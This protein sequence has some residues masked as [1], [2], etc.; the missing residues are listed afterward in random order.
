LVLIL[1]MRRV[2]RHQMAVRFLLFIMTLNPCLCIFAI[3]RSS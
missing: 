1:E 3:F 2:C